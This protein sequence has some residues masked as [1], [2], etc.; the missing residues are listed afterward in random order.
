MAGQTTGQSWAQFATVKTTGSN[1]KKLNS[2]QMKWRAAVSSRLQRDSPVAESSSKAA[3]SDTRTDM[4]TSAA[5]WHT[6]EL[7]KNHT[8][9]WSGSKRLLCGVE[10]RTQMFKSPTPETR[11]NGLRPHSPED[12][13]QVTPVSLPGTGAG[14]TGRTEEK[15]RVCPPAKP[16]S[17]ATMAHTS[18][19]KLKK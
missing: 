15:K 11:G 3:R 13:A 12:S 8:K 2:V 18:E 1:F 4:A 19:R 6:T 17:A 10:E 5:R 7:L 14:Q 16:A 9:Y